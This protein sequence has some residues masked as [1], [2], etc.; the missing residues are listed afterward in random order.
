MLDITRIFD[1]SWVSSSIW[2]DLPGMVAGQI[3]TWGDVSCESQIPCV[4]EDISEDPT[5][6]ISVPENTDALIT[7][8]QVDSR[9][10]QE[11]SGYVD[12]D[13]SFI[14][15]KKGSTKEVASSQ[16]CLRWQ[17]R[18][19]VAEVEL[20]SGEYVVHVSEIQWHSTEH[21]NSFAIRCESTQG[22]FENLYVSLWLN[23]KYMKL[24]PIIE[25]HRNWENNM[26]PGYLP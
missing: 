18:G 16:S 10:F 7:L 25:L 3:P 8:Q 21:A 23:Y 19:Q 5:V 6:T 24:T 11:I 4:F 2:I 22:I 13:L 12:Y 9:A 14:V 26:E 15:F 17:A 20:E 1:T